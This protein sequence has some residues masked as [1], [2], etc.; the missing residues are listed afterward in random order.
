M[1]ATAYPLGARPN[2]LDQ[3]PERA[4]MMQML[5]GGLANRFGTRAQ[6]TGTLTPQK[7]G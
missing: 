3:D 7:L 5:Q 4:Q 6:G 1:V 2:P